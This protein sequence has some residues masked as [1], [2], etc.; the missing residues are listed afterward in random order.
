MSIKIQIRRDTAS[1]WSTNNPTL[2][3]G[4]IGLDRTNNYF[5]VGDGTTAWNSLSQFT[6]NIENVEDLV[7]A[8]VSGNTESG[9]AVTY[10]LSLIHISEPTRPY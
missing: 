2:A 10:D 5:K 7:G 1:N 8:M 3:D 6:Q 4:E 9:I